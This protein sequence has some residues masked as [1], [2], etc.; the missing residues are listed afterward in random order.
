MKKV[1]SLTAKLYLLPTRRGI[2]IYHCPFCYYFFKTMTSITTLKVA[3]I[4]AKCHVLFS[5]LSFL[6]P[7]FEPKSM[8]E[9]NCPLPDWEMFLTVCVCCFLMNRG[10]HTMSS[11]SDCNPRI[12]HYAKKSWAT[13]HLQGDHWEYERTFFWCFLFYVSKCFLMVSVVYFYW[14][15]QIPDFT[16]VMRKEMESNMQKRLSAAVLS[17]PTARQLVT[18]SVWHCSQGALCSMSSHSSAWASSLN[19]L[20]NLLA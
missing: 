15:D 11:L 12:Q 4:P 16:R 5:V 13:A 6:N 1:S 10:T 19:G 20:S 17:H 14:R 7:D 2:Y 9:R 8:A 3:N 18:G